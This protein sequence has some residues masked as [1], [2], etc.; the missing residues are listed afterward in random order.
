MGAATAIGFG[1]RR[2]G[3]ARAF[4]VSDGGSRGRRVVVAG[5]RRGRA[6]YRRLT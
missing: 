2:G 5:R 4:A 1:V 6:L 3:L